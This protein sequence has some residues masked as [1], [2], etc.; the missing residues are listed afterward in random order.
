MTKV[1]T[2]ITVLLFSASTVFAGGEGKGE[3]GGINWMNWDEVQVAMKKEPKKVWVDV[4]TDWCGWCKVMDKKTFS[5]PE[6]IEYMNEHFYAVKFNA[7][8]KDEIMFMGKSYGFS[9][10]HNANLLAATLMNGRMSYPTNIVMQENF[11][12]PSPIP[13]YIKVP[14]IER[15]MKYLVE[16][17]YKTQKFEEYAKTF[18]PEW[19]AEQ[20]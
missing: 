19:K 1:I 14:D 16:G 9:P 5:N 13:G 4:Y 2:L 15:V 10:E 11:Q 17:H 12:G 7:E 20:G 18:K 3:K 8:R 6:V